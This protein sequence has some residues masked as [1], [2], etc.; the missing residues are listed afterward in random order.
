MKY[1][2]EEQTKAALMKML[3]KETWSGNHK[4]IFQCDMHSYFDNYAHIKYLVKF[5]LKRLILLTI[6]PLILPALA[7]AKQFHTMF[8]LNFTWIS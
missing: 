6:Y 2:R 3:P 8:I 4:I 1:K 7:V 5:S